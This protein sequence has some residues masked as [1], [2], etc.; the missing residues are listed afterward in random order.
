MLAI[1]K[2]VGIAAVMFAATNADDLVLLT[3]FFTQAG[4][5]PRQIVFG[6]LIGIG[7]L[8]AISL[9]AAALALAVPHGWLPWLGVIPIL[10]GLQ[11]LR[12]PAHSDDQ[13]AP[14]ALRWWSIAGI[15]IA[16]GADNLGVYTPQF[17]IQSAFEKTITIASFFVLTLVWCGLAWLA[18]RHPSLNPVISRVCRKAAPW[19]LIGLGLWIMAQH[20]IFGLISAS[21]A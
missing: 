19:V 16:N 18:V 4:C 3:L 1:L 5:S 21:A 20:P 11:W 17:A 2:I 14:V 10:I 9:V 7:A 13:S 12:R 6:Q 8:V 15:T